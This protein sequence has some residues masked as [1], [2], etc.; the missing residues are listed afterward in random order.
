[1]LHIF[2]WT[3]TRGCKQLSCGAAPEICRCNNALACKSSIGTLPRPCTSASA[4]PGKQF[5]LTCQCT[6]TCL[7]SR[8]R[9]PLCHWCGWPYQM[10]RTRD[11]TCS[12][13]S[14]HWPCKHNDQTHVL[15]VASLQTAGAICVVLQ[16]PAASGAALLC[17][18]VGVVD[19]AHPRR[20]VVA[21]YHLAGMCSHVS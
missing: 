9:V 18:G 15:A 14:C 3:R 16:R 12:V 2:L 17:L 11:A 19:I 7:L 21:A 6:P 10:L 4:A 8:D 5:S 20:R 13:Q 1:M